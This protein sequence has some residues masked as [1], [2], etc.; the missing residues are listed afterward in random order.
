MRVNPYLSVH[1][2]AVATSEL[3][4]MAERQQVP[5]DK[6]NAPNRDLLSRLA[7]RHG[8]SDSTE[9]WTALLAKDLE[10]KLIDE[11]YPHLFL[12]AKKAGDHIDQ[13]HQ[14]VLRGREVVINEDPEFHLVRYYERIYL[15]PL[16]GYLLNYTFWEKYLQPE[17]NNTIN[18]TQLAQRSLG[19]FDRHRTVVGFLRSYGYLIQHESD[20]VIAQKAHLL[21]SYVSFDR[22]QTF[23][24]SFR[25]APD[26]DVSDR[27][28][29]GQFR[30]T[31]LNWATRLVY[32][33]RLI[34]R[35]PPGGNR[36]KV[37]MEFKN[38]NFGQTFQIIS[39]YA[40]PLAFVFAL[41]S[42]VLS[43]MQVVITALGTQTWYAFLTVSW[44][45]SVAIMLFAL[46]VIAGTGFVVLSIL[47]SQLYFALK[48]KWRESHS[49]GKRRPRGS[50]GP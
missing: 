8:I 37:R 24:H 40:A 33:G 9:D 6:Q 28:M 45:F 32:L 4:P 30:L 44:G 39:R 31:R 21:P 17:S 47:L 13:L 50:E 10:T 29:Y 23:I 38:V 3:I 46:G 49:S 16:P 5:F 12:V 48:T 42:L 2:P 19:N 14:H 15:K 7:L 22:F 27:Y 34:S 20:F 11:L 1:S 26:E 25:V 41:L 36:H 43:S 18:A 35:P